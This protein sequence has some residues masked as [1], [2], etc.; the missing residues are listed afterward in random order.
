MHWA[1]DNEIECAECEGQGQ[2]DVNKDD[3]G[4]SFWPDC[5]ACNGTGLRAPTPDELDS[6]AEAAY[7]RQ[8]EGEPPI[9]MAERHEMDWKQKQELNR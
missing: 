3:R 8:F 5:K 6:M 2:I 9:S 4:P 1:T 7:D